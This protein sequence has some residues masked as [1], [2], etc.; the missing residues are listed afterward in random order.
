MS[1]VNEGLSDMSKFRIRYMLV[2]LY[3]KHKRIEPDQH[4]NPN[5][6]QKHISGNNQ[7]KVNTHSHKHR[8]NAH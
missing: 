5:S 3:I 1:N 2:D 7:D 4:K 8:T 6:V